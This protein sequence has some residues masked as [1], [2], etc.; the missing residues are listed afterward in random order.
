MIKTAVSLK[1]VVNLFDGIKPKIVPFYGLNNG[2]C[3]SCNL[4]HVIYGLETVVSV[5][6]SNTRTRTRTFQYCTKWSWVQ[7]WK[8]QVHCMVSKCVYL[9]T[10]TNITVL[11][12]LQWVP[13]WSVWMR[14]QWTK[15][16]QMKTRTFNGQ[17][18]IIY[19]I[20]MN[21]LDTCM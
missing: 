20:W 12:D 18:S 8:L 6:C 2:S 13:A 5:L 21:I 11:V 16:K 17:K 3:Y 7:Y 9:Q 1:T 10:N 14:K 19:W 4:R 15:Q